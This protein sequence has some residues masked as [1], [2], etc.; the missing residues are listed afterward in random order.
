MK[1]ILFLIAVLFI[2]LQSF[3]IEKFG[4]FS[5]NFDDSIVSINGKEYELVDFTCR[6][7]NDYR[8]IDYHCIYNGD[9]FPKCVVF[10]LYEYDNGRMSLKVGNYAN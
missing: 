7:Y 4:G 2:S 3:K 10:H 8:R 9:G 5:V 6:V 1:K